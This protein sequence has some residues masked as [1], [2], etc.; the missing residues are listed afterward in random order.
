MVGED[1]E[2]SAAPPAAA[3]ETGVGGG[4]KAGGKGGGGGAEGMRKGPWTPAEDE[5]L[6]EHVRRHGE[7][8]WN[9]VQRLSGLARCGKS[10]RLRWANHLRPNLK[11]GSFAPEEEF[12]ILRLH[13]QLGNKWARMAA[14]LP[15]RTDN[16][17][18]NYWNT[19]L[20]RRQRA[21]LPIYPPELQDAIRFGRRLQRQNQASQGTP[22]PPLLSATRHQAQ[23]PPLQLP[24]LLDLVSFCPQLEMTPPPT[25]H[26]CQ[27]SF[28]FPVPSLSP[29]TT[30]TP[31]LLRKPQ[32]GLCNYDFNPP[33]LMSPPYA[34]KMELPSNQLYQEAAG[35]GGPRNCGLTEPLLPEPHPLG[36]EHIKTGELLLLPAVDDHAVR[37]GNLFC[38][39]DYDC[40]SNQE[41][42]M[43][44]PLQFDF[45]LLL[46]GTE[47]NGEALGSRMKDMAEFLD[48][49]APV[50]LDW[51]NSD[52]TELSSAQPST[53]VVGEDV[54]VDM[55]QLAPSQDWNVNS[56]PWSNMPGIC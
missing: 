15:G 31:S 3:A 53:V 1:R 28:A 37:W 45:A 41:G 6:L 14:Q 34:V 7:G 43:E 22:P 30:P 35:G 52:N 48:L 17:I 4:K 40:G 9:A 18:K 44:T 19:R 13:A 11:K 38:A 47:G 32:M 51:C 2:S 8:N 24:P 46:A 42:T 10:C 56:W 36:L 20:K 23:L 49:P 50:V 54:A 25:S 29:P 27:L 55:Q 16:E 12:L 33:T 21:G 39:G 5:I 26:P